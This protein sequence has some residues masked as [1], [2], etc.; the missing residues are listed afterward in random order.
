VELGPT[1]LDVGEVAPRED[2]NAAEPSRRGEIAELGHDLGMP[3][4]DMRGLDV[5]SLCVRTDGPPG[6]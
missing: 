1:G 5:P 6:V 3:C 4:L 2:V